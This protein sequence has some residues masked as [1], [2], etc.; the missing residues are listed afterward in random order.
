[1]KR[2]QPWRNWSKLALLSVIGTILVTSSAN[3]QQ[4]KNISTSEKVR[5]NN[6]ISAL[7]EKSV[8]GAS[9]GYRVINA[10]N[11]ASILAYHANHYFS[12]A[13]NTKLF[14][15]TAILRLLGPNYHFQT[16][17]G[18]QPSARHKDRIQG[19]LYLHFSG[20]PS[21]TITDLAQLFKKIKIMGINTIDGNIVLDDTIFTGPNH[22]LGTP[23]DDLPFCYSAPATSIILNHNCFSINLKLAHNRFIASPITPKGLFGLHNNLVVADQKALLSCVFQPHVDSRNQLWLNGCFPANQRQ[24][25]SFA[26]QNPN[27]FAK[28]AIARILTKEHLQLN[29]KIINGKI[30]QPINIAAQHQSAPLNHMVQH[31]LKVSDNV[32]AMSFDRTLGKKVYGIGSIKAGVSAIKQILKPLV[33]IDFNKVSLEDG[34]GFSRYNLVS[35][36]QLTALLFSIYHDPMLKKNIMPGLPVAG[37]SGSLSN[38]MKKPPLVNKVW[39]KTGTMHNVTTLSGYLFVSPKKTLIFSI[40]V[41]NSIA[42]HAKSREFQESLLKKLITTT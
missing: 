22:S 17:I 10:D 23:V 15:A 4:Y 3:A 36:Q 42:G 21:L 13:S 8:P 11:G 40:M 7:A 1:M 38:R 41:N 24:Y 19:N 29:G 39:A 27:L 33:K 28:Q 9:I 2:T 5:L 31:M 20:D 18:W 32:Y 12:P 14:T 6:T 34:A 16:T 30:P 25:F 35:P 37:R 26:I